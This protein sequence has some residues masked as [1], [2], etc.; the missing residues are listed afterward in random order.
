MATVFRTTSSYDCDSALRDSV[1]YEAARLVTGASKGTSSATLYKALALE[2]FSSRRKLHIS[3]HSAILRF[4]GK[5][6][7]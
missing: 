6:R 3:R 4:S 1:Q 5:E 7:K 2:P